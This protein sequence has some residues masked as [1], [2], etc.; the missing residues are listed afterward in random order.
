MIFECVVLYCIPKKVYFVQYWLQDG[1]KGIWTPKED[2][3]SQP[4]CLSDVHDNIL[5]DTRKDARQDNSCAAQ[6]EIKVYE[7]V[8]LWIDIRWQQY[9][10]I[11][12]D[13][14]DV[15]GIEKITFIWN[16]S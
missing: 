11:I 5:Q 1:G 4:S 2:P 8:G 12:C 15:C 13:M 14:S 6:S 3:S 16:F 9:E 10:N 7:I